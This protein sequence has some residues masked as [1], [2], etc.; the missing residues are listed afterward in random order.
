MDSGSFLADLELRPFTLDDTGP[1]ESFGLA[2]GPGSGGLEIAVLCTK[3]KPTQDSLRNAWKSRQGGRATPV[4]LVALHGDRAALCGPSGESP[5]VFLDLD[6]GQVERI[7]RTALDEPNR[8]AATRFLWSVLPEVKES[9]IPG[10]R[11]QGLFATHE[12]EKGVPQRSD[13]AHAQQ[14]AKLMLDKRGRVLLESLGYQIS[15]TKQPYAVLRCGQT[16]M[17]VAVFLDRSEACD[18]ASDRF[19]G[20]TPVQYALAKADDE[21]LDYVLVDHGS[22][23]RI[24]TTAGKGVG[25]RGRTETFVEIHLDL[26]PSD[27]AGYLW[28]LF[29]GQALSKDGSFSKVLE[30]SQDYASDLGSRLRDRIYDFVVP[31]LAIAIAKARNLEKPT[32]EDLKHTYEMALLVLFRLLFIA[33]AEDKDL[34]PC[35][36]NERY[37]DR[38]LKKKAREMATLRTAGVSTVACVQDAPVPEFDDSTTHWEEAVRLFRVVNTGKPKEW[39][40]PAYNGGMFSEEA[41]V[42]PAGSLLSDIILPNKDFGPVLCD[43][44]VDPTPEGFGPV[45]FRSLGVREFGTVYEGLLE[46]ELSVA[47]ENLALDKEGQYVPAGKK[48]PKVRKGHVYLHNA[49]GA[50]KATGSYYTKSFA[51][52]HLLDHALEPAITDHLARLDTL[53]DRRAAESFFDFR[54]AD[55]AMGS[56]HFLVAAVDRIE[57]RLSSYLVKRP[58]PGVMGELQRL[59]QSALDGIE[60]AGGSAEGIEMENNRLLRRQIARRCIYGVDINNIAVQLARLSLWIHTFVPGLPLSFLDHN[61]VCGNSLVGIATF[62]EVD[63]LLT[64]GGT[65]PLF[66]H[67]ADALIG[68]A[69]AAVKRLG[70][71]SDAN[72][73]EIKEARKAFEQQRKAV[74]DT[75]R[76]FD[77]L[78]ASRLPEAEISLL[79][80]D[81][82]V[83]NELFVQGTHRRAM[84]A[85]GQLRPFHF[86][87]AFPEVFL[88]DRAGFDVILGNPPWKEA[89]LEEDGFW[90]RYKPGFK[91]LDLQARATVKRGM[92][93]SRPDLVEIYEREAA[94]ATRLRNSLINGPYPGMGIGDADL[95]KAFCW[96]F[97]SL[98]VSSSGRIGVVLPRS[99]FSVKGSTAFRQEVFCHA[100]DVDL[101]VLLN[102]KGWVFDDAEHRYTICLCAI[103]KCQPPRRAVKMRGPFSTLNRF[104]VGTTKP[105]SEFTGEDAAKWTDT[106]AL[107]LLPSEESLGIFVILRKAPRLDFVDRESWRVRPLAEEIHS[108]KEQHLMR[109]GDG[110]DDDWPVYKGESFDLWNPDTGTY[111]GWADSDKTVTYLQRKRS[112]GSNRSNSPFFEFRDRPGYLKKRDSLPCMTPRIVIRRVTNRTNQRTVLA[113]LAPE[114]VFVADQA[115]CLLW[116][117]GDEKDIAYVLGVLASIPLDWYARRFVETDVR[118]HIINPLPVP[119]P[120]R[121][122]PLWQRT[123]S[124]AG[125]LACPDKRFAKWAKAVGVECGKLDADE[126][127]D[128][129]AELDAVVAHLYGLTEPQLTHIFETFHEGWDYQPRL[130][131][132]LGH[133]RAWVGKS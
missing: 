16:K 79:P 96:R 72:A 100:D 20:M 62:K 78:T 116:P 67:T 70:Q 35:R 76:M 128:M 77:I 37:R 126:K 73:S 112:T 40:V 101:T 114:H 59:R 123:V 6:V 105:P 51:V 45:D 21:N 71:L 122:N 66:S 17:A 28:L 7:C 25:R 84:E 26:L 33:Y 44:L 53:D 24:H 65:T 131:A 117:R 14:K 30:A 108:R 99:A 56:G 57:C 4:L 68:S 5:P 74:A 19:G 94:T 32:A 49:S 47:E 55:I 87:I 83:D 48:E 104:H 13:W 121:D 34:L 23:L 89:K 58:L 81:F 2:I 133:Y 120:T 52:E 106:A 109:K 115:S 36:T 124:L 29:S 118:L 113:A 15:D 31:R 125:R 18:V 103:A 43:L 61:I 91:G 64:R 97:W 8:H 69:E 90:S 130:A 3:R 102:T 119:R 93:A 95:Y 54:V 80:E 107:P 82:E 50:R 98:I 86:P 129:I 60:H 12:L 92:K 63:D 127:N 75:E 38:S 9:K 132:V 41:D 110:K 42:S 39:G 46:S 85:L 111:Y 88:R 22:S 1:L 11:N 27:R 10:L